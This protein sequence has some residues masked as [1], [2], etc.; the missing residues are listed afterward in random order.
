MNHVYQKQQQQYHPLL[1]IGYVMGPA[2][3]IASHLGIFLLFL[4]GLSWQALVWVIILH[5][6]RSTSLTAI[7]HRLIIHKAYQS[8]SIVKWIGSFIASSSAQMG[9]SW[10]KGHHLEAH[11]Q[12]SDMEGDR[13]SPNYPF[14]GMKGFWWSQVGWFFSKSF[15]PHNLPSD[16]E[17]DPVLKAID[18]LH[19]IP[20]LLLGLLSYYIG[21]LEFV[22]A[23]CLSTALLYHSTCSVNSLAHIA[24]SQ[25]FMTTDN[26]RNNWFVALVTMGEG[27]HN[28]HHAV[29]WSARHG[30][31]IR[32]G[33]I[34]RLPDP[35]YW[36]IKLLE[37]FN[38]AWNIKL[39][40]DEYLLARANNKL[41]VAPREIV[42]VN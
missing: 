30:Y 16:V 27:W 15:F 12:V 19:F 13:H 39:P 25:P 18:R 14:T 21:G 3:I 8:P 4:T 24:G 11:H 10:W 1:A 23:F 36:F 41:D 22:G 28:L 20:V 26:S 35:T 34:A 7:Y 6:I 37:R 32:D 17:S 33:K 29:Q 9:P 5:V 40:S 31:T 38:L 42:E 2:L